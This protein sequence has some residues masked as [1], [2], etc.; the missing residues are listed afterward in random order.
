MVSHLAHDA[1]F[2]DEKFPIDGFYA[3]LTQQVGTIR[4]DVKAAQRFAAV[5]HSYL[6]VHLEAIHQHILAE[7]VGGSRK[8]MGISI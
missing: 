8:L 1:I 3:V 5:G 4:E 2:N 6:F 7:V